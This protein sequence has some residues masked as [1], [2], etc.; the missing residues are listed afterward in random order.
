MQWEAEMNRLK[1]E[2]RQTMDMYNSACKEAVSANQTVLSKLSRT[3]RIKVNLNYL[4]KRHINGHLQIKISNL[5]H[6]IF[7]LKLKNT[8]DAL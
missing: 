5:A 6:T 8:G 3:A 2:L 4:G 7:I 1:L